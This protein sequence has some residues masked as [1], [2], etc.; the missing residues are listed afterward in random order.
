M[1]TKQFTAMIG[2]VIGLSLSVS[3]FAGQQY[4]LKG[5]TPTGTRL[6]QIDAT[7]ALPFDK[8]Y[9]ELTEQQRD[10]YRARFSGIESDQVPPFPR[11]GLQE[12][13]R[14]LI[15]ANNNGVSGQLSLQVV[16]NEL[17]QVEDLTVLNAPNANVAEKSAAAIRNTQFEPGYCAG[18]PCKMTLP[19]QIKYL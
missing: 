5:D 2:T 16:I 9:F 12:V 19:V 15:D 4:A 18:A 14:P 11:N 7:A 6:Q 8:Q 10:T 3:A 17:G 13:Y 1:K